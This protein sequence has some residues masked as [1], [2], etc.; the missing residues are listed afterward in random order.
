MEMNISRVGKRIPAAHNLQLSA[1][2]STLFALAAA[3]L[4]LFK[5][6]LPSLLSQELTY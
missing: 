3:L 5:D 6:L 4:I 1:L 2:L